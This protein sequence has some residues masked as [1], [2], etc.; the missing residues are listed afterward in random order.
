MDGTL[1]SVHPYYHAFIARE[2][3]CRPA[4]DLAIESMII[5]TPASRT[6]RADMREALSNRNNARGHQ[7]SDYVYEDQT[8]G[9]S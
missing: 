4:I 8:S 1:I 9:N 6:L 7:K 2:K 5:E 3:R